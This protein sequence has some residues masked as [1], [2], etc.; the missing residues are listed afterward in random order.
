MVRLPSTSMDNSFTPIRSLRFW[1]E[2][3]C[4]PIPE[5]F[6]IYTGYDKVDVMD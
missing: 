5:W 4:W 2:L 6:Y 1:L 3:K